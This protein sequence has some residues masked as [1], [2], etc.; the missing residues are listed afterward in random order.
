MENQYET[1]FE[2]ARRQMRQIVQW[3]ELEEARRQIAEWAEREDIAKHNPVIRRPIQKVCG[4]VL[5]MLG[6]SLVVVALLGLMIR[7]M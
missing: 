7:L 3:A 2:Q 5:C 4:P 1:D 6:G